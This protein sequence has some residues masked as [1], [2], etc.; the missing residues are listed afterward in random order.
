[1]SKEG[2]Q[3]ERRK[4]KKE[5]KKESQNERQCMATVLFYISLF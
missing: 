4:G 5:R 2:R 3:G 1:M